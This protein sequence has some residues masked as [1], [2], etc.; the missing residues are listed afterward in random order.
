[1]AAAIKG[2]PLKTVPVD[3]FNGKPMRLTRRDGQPVVYSVGRD[4]KDD[5]AQTDSDRN[6]RPTGDLIYRLLPV[7]AKR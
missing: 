4:G 2:S 1:M 7:Q 6:Q 5:G 3:P